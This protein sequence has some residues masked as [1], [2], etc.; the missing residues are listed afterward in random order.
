M[1]IIE[2]HQSTKTVLSTP[3][4]VFVSKRETRYSEITA[5]AEHRK[6]DI[7]QWLQGVASAFVMMGAFIRHYIS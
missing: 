4:S 1:K 3:S 7:A 2:V 6:F 5:R